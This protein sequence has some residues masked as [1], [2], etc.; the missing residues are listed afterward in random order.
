[1][2]LLYTQ[3]SPYARKVRVVALEKGIELTLV[4]ENLTQKSAQLF[5]ANPLAKIPTLITDDGQSFFDS[6]MICQY[7][8]SLNNHPDLIPDEQQWSILRWE[9]FADGIMDNMV[10]IYL[11]NA[12]HPTD[13]N[14]K[15][16]SGREQNTQHL[17]NYLEQHLETLQTL[18]L[19]SIAVACAVESVNFYQ[20]QLNSEGTYPQLQQWLAEFSQRPSLLATAPTR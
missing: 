17:L 10:G 13:S 9:A 2:Q 19:A 14:Q 6:P 8:N 15:F 3:R 5:A 18:S 12:R 16:I 11:E 1:M 7:L 4:E 20:P